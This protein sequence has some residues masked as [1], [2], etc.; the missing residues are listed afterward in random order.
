MSHQ[1]SWFGVQ[2]ITQIT[3]AL[4][5]IERQERKKRIVF[6][7][8]SGGLTVCPAGCLAPP[9][10]L[11]LQLASE[12]G[13]AGLALLLLPGPAIRHLVHTGYSRHSSL[14]CALPVGVAPAAG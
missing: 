13:L 12:G 4:T 7:G 1:V 11:P 14:E 9:L 3:A 10:L 5:R 6:L 8:L 2:R